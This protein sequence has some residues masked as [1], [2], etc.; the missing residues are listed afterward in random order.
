MSLDKCLM[1]CIHHC[2][3]IQ[4]SFTALEILH[5]L[6]SHPILHPLA[7]TNLFTVSRVLPFP[8]CHIVEIIL[9]IAL[10]DWLL[11]AIR[12]QDSSM[13][14]HSSIVHFFIALNNISLYGYQNLFIHSPIE[15][16]LSCFQVLAVMN[17]VAINIHVQVYVCVC[18][19]K[20]SVQ[21]SKYQAIQLLDHMV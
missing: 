2:S 6:P 21:L 10:P 12:I 13:S 17:K 5:A 20:F 9:Y 4:S 15:E 19:L 7:T 14:F 16:C 11:S 8:E 18:V 1:A 3:T